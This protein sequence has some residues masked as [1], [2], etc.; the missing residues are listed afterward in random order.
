MLAMRLV[1]FLTLPWL[2][3]AALLL[4]SGVAAQDVGLWIRADCTTLTGPVAGQTW[5][6]DSTARLLKV[7]DGSAYVG[8]STGPYAIR[9]LVGQN[10]ATTPNTKY[11]V[12]ADLVQLRNPT[13]GTVVIRTNTGTLT[14]DILLAGPAANG[15]DQAAVFAV[16]TWLHLYFI[17]NGTTLATLSSIVA[18][19]TGPTLPT[20]YTHWAYAGAVYNDATPLLVKTRLRG[21]LAF[22]ETQQTALSGGTQATTEA[23]VSLATLVPPNAL[24]WRA[25]FFEGNA[26]TI[27]LRVVT[28]SEYFSG[29]S[30]ISGLWSLTLPNIAQQFF[31][32]GDA[33]PSLTV[34]VTGYRVPNGGD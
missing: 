12:S 30:P 7:W 4:P 29:A 28:G 23:T 5:C 14:N 6:F 18:P 9:N 27:H 13:T 8:S 19:P 33:N 1:R 32:F 24:D 22:Y 25:N 2:L 21:T 31:Y 34:Q 10:D 11:G 3:A 26:T 16:S 20:G 17:W 15:R